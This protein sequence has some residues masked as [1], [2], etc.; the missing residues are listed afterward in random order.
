MELEPLTALRP[1]PL[2]DVGDMAAAAQANLV[3]L[4]V[5]ERKLVGDRSSTHDL[6]VPSPGAV[7][8]YRQTLIPRDVLSSYDFD[9]LQLRVREVWGQYCLFCWFFHV[10]DP[11]RPPDF[12]NLP[13]EQQVRCP[14]SLSVKT[15]EIEKSLW[16]LRFEQRL[17]GDADFRFDPRFDELYQAALEIPVLVLGESVGVCSD[18]VLLLGSCEF[19]GMLAAA[20]WIGDDRWVWAQEDIMDL[21]QE[22]GV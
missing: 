21:P 6:Q 16:R 3:Q 12:K 5:A 2:N 4:R 8:R 1:R 19:A 18:E 7:T 14:A 13:V 20:R 11:H 17:R 15:L 22:E 10:Q 9:A